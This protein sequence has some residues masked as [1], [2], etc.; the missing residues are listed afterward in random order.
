MSSV[1]DGGDPVYSG[2]QRTCSVL[3]KNTGPINHSIKVSYSD[4]A[5]W[6]TAG[7]QSRFLAPGD[8][9]LI[10]F[11]VH[12]PQ[13]TPLGSISN[14][15]ALVESLNDPT[16]TQ[17]RAG[18]STVVLQR[19]DV[20]F[21]GAIDLSD[22]SVLVSYVLGVGPEPQ[23]TLEAGNFNC[24]AGVDLSDLSYMIAFLVGGGTSSPCNPY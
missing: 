9:S 23:P 19:G 21:S 20:D 24:A 3:V 7:N 13:A 22:L 17:T 12:P 14:I 1:L 18:T 15:T 11:A 10:L 6:V 8:S 2:N 16:L 5:G 4:N